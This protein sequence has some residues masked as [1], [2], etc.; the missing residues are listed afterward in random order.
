MPLEGGLGPRTRRKVEW[1]PVKAGIARWLE[2]NAC[3]DEPHIVRQAIDG[4]T[5]YRYSGKADVELWL[6]E[7]GRHAWPGGVPDSAPTEDM[8]SVPGTFSA[9]EKIWSFFA[10]HHGSRRAV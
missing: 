1:P 4:L 9:S 6:V 5:G 10:S 7:G 8:P 2:A 3:K